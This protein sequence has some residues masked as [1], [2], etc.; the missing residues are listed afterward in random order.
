MKKLLLLLFSLILSLNSYGEKVLYCQDEL[1]QGITYK[2]GIW[3]KA[4]FGLQR[5]TLKFNDD[6]SS[7]KGL[8]KSYK[9]VPSECNP[10]MGSGNEKFIVC[11]DNYNMGRSFRYNKDNK[12]YIFVQSQLYGYLD[13]SGD[14]N[15]WISAGTCV[16]F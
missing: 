15:D 9:N 12:R 10:A 13:G 5:H 11:N 1:A 2:N 8:I 16:D 6:Y 4:N 3:Q 14:D 7:I